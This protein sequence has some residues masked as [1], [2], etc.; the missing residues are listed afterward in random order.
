MGLD[1]WQERQQSVDRAE[2]IDAQH[3]IPILAGHFVQWLP[4]AA[5]AGIVAKNMH[6][7]EGFG[8]AFGGRVHGLPVGHVKLDGK[9]LCAHPR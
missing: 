6:L 2:K 4:G 9:A 7:A 8:A 1:L 5:D 3:P